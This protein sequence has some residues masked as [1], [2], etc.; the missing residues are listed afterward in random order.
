[1]DCEGF[2]LRSKRSRVVSSARM[3]F[4]EGYFEERVG[5]FSERIIS[6]GDP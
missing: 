4:R 2:S 3:G 5:V 1:M 6:T